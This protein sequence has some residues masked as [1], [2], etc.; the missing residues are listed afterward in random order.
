[1][2][3]YK[4]RQGTLREDTSGGWVTWAETV[5]ALAAKDVELSRIKDAAVRLLKFRERITWGWCAERGAHIYYLDGSPVGAW[6]S[7]VLAAEAA[8]GG[9]ER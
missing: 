7:D 3:R 2:N 5:A 9:G 1:M 6:L 4:L 8:K